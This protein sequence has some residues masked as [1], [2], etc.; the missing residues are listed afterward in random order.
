MRRNPSATVSTLNSDLVVADLV[1]NL[2]H[3]LRTPVNHIVGFSEILQEEAVDRSWDSLLPDLE[4]IR[5]AGRGLADYI[6]TTV[7]LARVTAGAF[8][9]EQVSQDLRTPLESIIGYSQLLQEVVEERG[10]AEALPDLRKIESA[11]NQ[12]TTLIATVLELTK[13]YAGPAQAGNVDPDPAVSEASI[14]VADDNDLDRDMVT[15]RVEQ[16]GYTVRAVSSGLEAVAQIV[17]GGAFDLA[18]VDVLMPEQDGLETLQI[19]KATTP[20]LPVL[21][22]S[23]IEEIPIVARCIELGAED[24]LVKPVD[25]VLLRAKIGAALERRR[26]RSREQ[27]YD[28]QLAAL[29][30]AVAA[31]GQ[32]AFDAA[33]IADLTSRDD[34][35]GR[36]ARVFERT[37]LDLQSRG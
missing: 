20:D 2:R 17:E 3:Q 29:T 33:T 32:G 24:Y 12:L 31:L 22:I 36:L 34:A 11:A 13:I 21:M 5:Q 7:D 9:P 14:L 6:G 1:R 23:A 18:L 37:A 27:A 30:A 26:L 15:R 16:L 10:W 19:F 4:R 35:L 28:S 8:D 25:A